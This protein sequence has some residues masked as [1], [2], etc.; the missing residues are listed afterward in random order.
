MANKNLTGQT[1]ADSY[2]Q[3]LIT[4]DENGITGSGTSATQIM[5]GTGVAGAGG[6]DTTPLYLSTTR[7]G[8]GAAAP[9][10]TLELRN[11]HSTAYHGTNTIVDSTAVGNVGLNVTNYDGS[12]DYATIRLSVRSSNSAIWDIVNE[13]QDANDGDLIF[14]TRNASGSSLEAMRLDQDGKVGIGTTAPVQLLEVSTVNGSPALGIGVRRQ[15]SSTDSIAASAVMGTIYFGAHQSSTNAKV[16]CA[17]IHAESDADWTDSS[18][19]PGKLVFS[20]VADGATAQSER[21]TIKADGNVGIGTDSP[22]AKLM[23][24]DTSNPAGTSAAPGSVAI[25]GQRDGSANVLTFQALDHSAAGSALP[26]GQGANIRWQGFDG[27]DFENM[28]FISVTADGQAVANGDAPSKMQFG[29]SAD[30]SSAPG[31]KMTIKQDGNV[32]IGTTAPDEKLHVSAGAVVAGTAVATAGGSEVLI[33]H[34]APG[35]QNWIS[36]IATENSSGAMAVGYACKPKA[37]DTGSFVSTIAGSSQSRGC[38]VIGKDL[39]Y[40]SSTGDTT[41]A[42]D[43]DVT[44]VSRFYIDDANGNVG[45]GTVSPGS[46]LT[47]GDI[48][49]NVDTFIR[50]EADTGNQAGIFLYE[51]AAVKWRISNRADSANEFQIL[52]HDHAQGVSLVQNDGDGFA[53]VSD[54]RWKTDWTE[55]TGAI[56]GINTLRAGKYK[57]KNL[58]NG[59]IPDVWNSG[60]IAQDVEKILPDCVHTAMEENIEK[61]SLSYQALIPYLVKAIQ[62][63]SAKVTALENA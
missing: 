24:V 11:D 46:L 8:I 36:L 63:L 22:T 19:Y 56:D 33:S 2:D 40:L 51:E 28:G 55:Y 45:I 48:T 32:G 23:I 6:A 21:M 10:S 29:V 14:R 15:T 57:F 3:L 37:S 31:V 5:T 4:A 13:Y 16:D 26:D 49:A 47:V 43:S 1:I 27:T 54:E 7:V 35:D 53:V 52:D 44:L 17:R 61:K 42:I 9:E 20:T 25:R 39:E 18:D 50:I 58:V 62:E 34:Y 60:L 59:N 41:T 12:A 38:L 30:T